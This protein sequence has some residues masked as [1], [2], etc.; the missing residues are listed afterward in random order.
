MPGTVVL[1]FYNKNHF[2]HVQL[3]HDTVMGGRSDGA[4]NMVTEPAGL[5]F[6]GNL[7]LA[8]NGG[9]ASAEFR[10]TNALP[11]QHFSSIKLHVAADGRTYQLRLKTPYL[12][13]GVAYVANFKSDIGQ[14]HY[15]FQPDAF[16]GRY[17]GR[18]VTQL[19]KL[20]FADVTQLSVMLA[21]EKNGPFS[22]ILY[23][24]GLS[25]TQAI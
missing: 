24:L 4:V 13:R 10:L 2:S 25:T 17:R 15:Y 20:N 12:P 18:E 6:F 11:A 5:R 7:S 3:V 16:S 14:Q 21:D 9:F 19:P 8:N 22:I 1:E 23:S